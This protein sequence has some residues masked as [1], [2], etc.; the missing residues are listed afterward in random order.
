MRMSPLYRH[1]P[2]SRKWLLHCENPAKV[3]PFTPCSAGMRV[4]ANE[5]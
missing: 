5:R 2:S 1:G 3:V 4:V